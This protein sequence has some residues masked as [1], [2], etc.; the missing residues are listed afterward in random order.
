M[1]EKTETI[2]CPHHNKPIA[3]VI[4]EGR[5]V[6]YCTCV[7]DSQFHGKRVWLQMP[8][9]IKPAEVKKEN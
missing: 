4:E 5:K 7:P 9:D 3:V 2:Q 1:T 8:A 6:A